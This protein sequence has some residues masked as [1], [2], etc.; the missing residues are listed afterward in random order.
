MAKRKKMTANELREYLESMPCPF[1]T[2]GVTDG[3][4]ETISAELEFEMR[5]ISQWEKDG[6]INH[7]KASE[8]ETEF[9]ENLCHEHNIPYYED[10]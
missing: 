5:D 2:E 6:T 3:E 1:C 4:L 9:L 8:Y 7:D 10:L